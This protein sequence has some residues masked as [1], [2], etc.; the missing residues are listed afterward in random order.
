MK[1]AELIFTA[2]LVPVDFLMIILAALAAYFLR[3]S[4]Y[5]EEIRPVIFNLPFSSYLKIILPVAVVWILVFSFSGLYSNKRSRRFIDEFSKI[6]SACTVGIMLILLAIFASRELFD[7]RFIVLVGWIFSFIFVFFG[8]FFIT[9][10][11][12]RLFKKGI[13]VHNLLVVGDDD[14]TKNIIKLFETKTAFGYRVIKVIKDN[15]EKAIQEVK[16]F[17]ENKKIDEIL[18]GENFDS[19]ASSLL[20]DFC[21][22]HHIVYKYIPNLFETKAINVEI[23]DVAGVP[24]IELKKTPLDGWKKILKRVIDIIGS[25]IGIIIFSPLMMLIAIKIKLD[26]R[27]PIFF[28]YKRMGQ[29]EKPFFYFKFRSMIDGA[30]KMRYDSEFRSK[31]EDTRGWNEDNPMVKYKNDP[32]ITKIGK[33]LRKTSLDELPEFFNVL[34]GKMSLVGPRPHEPEEVAK[35]KKQYK[36]LLTIKPGVTGFSQIS[37]RSD[38]TFEDEAKLDTYYIENWSLRIDLYILLKTPFILLKK[39]KAE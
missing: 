5:L 21:N 18:Q 11:Q 36:K 28:G 9:L 1:K 33:F 22:E 13:G 4:S 8:R 25:L 24:V 10:I 31:V 34:I 2:I 35:Y 19:R 6:F 15:S 12:R 26:S 14:A 7:S 29:H 38:L 30:H 39:R 17:V 16:Y 3:F 23:Q 20:V 32:R 37:G 27:G